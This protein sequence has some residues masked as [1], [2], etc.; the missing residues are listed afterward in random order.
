MALTCFYREFSTKM[1]Y[2]FILKIINFRVGFAHKINRY[3]HYVRLRKK[4]LF[5]IAFCTLRPLW[6]SMTPLHAC[7]VSFFPVNFTIVISMIVFVR[8]MICSEIYRLTHNTNKMNFMYI[9]SPLNSWCVQKIPF[10]IYIRQ[11]Q[12]L[13]HSRC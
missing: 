3:K 5:P 10:H 7:S 11:S 6:S 12:T 13:S 9:I 2:C 4:K 8:V 1:F